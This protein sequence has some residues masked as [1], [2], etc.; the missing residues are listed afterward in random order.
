MSTCKEVPHV[1][2]GIDSKPHQPQVLVLVA[3]VV[4]V[5]G[6]NGSRM[7]SWITKTSW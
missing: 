2:L 3:I 7:S 6:N 5:L 4:V 1:V